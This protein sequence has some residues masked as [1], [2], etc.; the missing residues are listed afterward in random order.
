LFEKGGPVGADQGTLTFMC[1]AD[2]S[3]T[4][5]EVKR[6][7]SMMGKPDNIFHCGAVGSGV[8]VKAINNYLSGVTIIACS[9]AMNIG[10]KL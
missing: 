8:A 9:E 2:S 1:G 10:V 7:V 5:E 6:V 4:F 3:E